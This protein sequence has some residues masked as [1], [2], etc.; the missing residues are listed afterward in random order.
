[1][2]E[3]SLITESSLI[4]DDGRTVLPSADPSSRMI[5]L[6]ARSAV[7]GLVGGLGLMTA[8]T[9]GAPI[10]LGAAIMGMGAGLL[11]SGLGTV[12]ASLGVFRRSRPCPR[13]IR[14]SA[15]VGLPLG[16]A[17]S[18]LGMTSLSLWPALTGI[19]NGLTLAAGVLGTLVVVLL[20]LGFVLGST[21]G[22]EEES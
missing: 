18:L 11:M 16:G 20:I 1:M 6:G 9:V 19:V 21:V 8:F 2:H 22:L 12:T 15:V 14:V 7:W 17:L 3:G 10:S 5:E 13:L 4:V